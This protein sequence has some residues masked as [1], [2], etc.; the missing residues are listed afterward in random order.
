MKRIAVALATA[1]AA[2]LGIVSL[3]QQTPTAAADVYTDPGYHVVNGREWR[4][5]CEA[6]SS[7]VDRCRAEIKATAIKLEGGKF[8]ETTDFVFN[9]LTYKPSPRSSWKGNP[10]GETGTWTAADGRQWRT[11][12]DTATTGRNGCR[13]YTLTTVYAVKTMTPRTY[14][15]KNQWIFNNIVQ[16]EAPKPK[17]PAI[18]NDARLPSGFALTKD[19][20]PYVKKAP[21]T[22]VDQYNPTSIG[23]F[24][25][26]VIA[27]RN[28]LD[29]KSQAAADQK[30][31]ALLAA[32]HLLKGSETTSYD[33]DGNGSKETVRWFPYMFAYKANPTIAQ[34]SPPWHSGL[35]QGG[36]LSAFIQL[37]SLTGE[38]KWLD[39]GAQAFNSFLVPN[40]VPGGFVNR[41]EGFLWFEEYP[42][43]PATT[44]LNGHLEAVIGLDLWYAKTKNPQAKA[45]VD[46]AL[47]DLEPELAKMEVPTDGG[48][49]TSYDLVRGYEAAPLRLVGSNIKLTT[50]R[51]NGETPIALKKV[52]SQTP[53]S[54]ALTTNS[55]FASASGGIA[56]G[57]GR[58]G[59][60]QYSSAVYGYYRTISGGNAWQGA[61]QT[62][63]AGRFSPGEPLTLTL[64]ANVT[65]PTNKAGASGRVAAYS[66]CSTG[67]TLL[68]ENVVRGAGWNDYTF[69]FK[70]PATGCDLLFQFMI[71]PYTLAGTT[72]LWDDVVVRKAD[73][74]GSGALVTG[75]RFYDLFV[76]RTPEN[77][78]TL[79]GSG[80]ATLQAYHNNRWQDIMAVT[81]T[82]A[83]QDIPVP[84]QFTGRNI[85]M[86]YHE[87]HVSELLT[88]YRRTGHQ[89]LLTYAQRWAPLAPSTG[90]QVPKSSTVSTRTATTDLTDLTEATTSDE[91]LPYDQGLVDM[92]TGVPYD[93]LEL[94]EEMEQP[95]S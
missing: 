91:Q 57:W 25:K 62:I 50:A 53:A 3:P 32:D 63:K 43:K 21:Y 44:V 76:H 10:L 58:L 42:T 81:L 69:G 4:T 66:V 93:Q 77:T 48:L 41:D 27:Y 82:D 33:T 40:S 16:F 87:T 71:S 65:K 47:A 39:Y 26:S 84:E 31:L 35:A 37:N 19:G 7:N 17:P 59:S 92:F 80:K 23:N 22:P 28:S 14:E 83:A 13:S 38:Q 67:T 52:T 46:E 75:T 1:L 70:A 79:R 90:W 18:C 61:Q 68:Y 5:T 60:S 29:P 56:T 89:Y 30:C 88:L 64:R 51:L 12:C 72:V 15:Q 6:Y 85:H 2:G 11:E 86:G 45:L 74:V 36:V 54:P 9:N 34:L 73:P 55:N 49:A 78:I 20:R 8:V 95:A 94:L 24:I